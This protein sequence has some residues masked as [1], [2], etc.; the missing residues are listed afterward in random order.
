MIRQWIVFTK[1]EFIEQLRTYRLLILMSVMFL[2]GIMS[3]VLAK[4]MPDMIKNM[5]LNGMQLTMPKATALDAYA[6][7]FK[8]MST[9]IIVLLLIY[10][11]TISNE[12]TKGTLINI[13][14]KGLPRA[15]VILSKYTAAVVLWT[16]GYALAAGTTIGYTI[17]LFQNNSVQNLFFSLFC[18]WL[19]GCFV[20]ALI[21]LSSTLTAGSFGGLILS[22]AALGVMLM[23]RVLPKTDNYNPITLASDNLALLKLTKESQELYITVGITLML[24][25]LCLYLSIVF[26]NKKKL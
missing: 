9:G 10:G 7:F 2:F 8:N 4:I 25:V 21:F 15:L 5:D 26:F 14:A 18:L 1:K 11:G 13:L 16:V 24:T 22:A 20:I 19:F 17:Y 12:L 6:Q 23:A 3:P